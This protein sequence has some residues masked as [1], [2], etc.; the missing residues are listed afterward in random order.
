M[1]LA[2]SSLS[3]I[4][5]FSISPSS[6]WNLLSLALVIALEKCKFILSW[7][8]HSQQRWHCQGGSN[9]SSLYPLWGGSCDKPSMIFF[10]MIFSIQHFFP[11]LLAC[12]SYYLVLC[13]N[14]F[15]GWCCVVLHL[16]PSCTLY[17]ILVSY[18]LHSV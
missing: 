18:L 9:I 7:F 15:G 8:G 16:W 5:E 17:E 11:I 6:S 3:C 10:F 14:F 12:T 4:R 13:G 2:S 1:S